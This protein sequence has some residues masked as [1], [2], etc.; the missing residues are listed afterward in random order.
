[1]IFLAETKEFK[2][3]TEIIEEPKEKVKNPSKA[4]YVPEI[5]GFTS[6]DGTGYDFEVYLPGVDKDTIRVR[7]TNEYFGILGETD[8]KQYLGTYNFC[9]PVNPEKAS[10]VYKEGLLKIH[11]PFEEVE[12][13]TIDVGVS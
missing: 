6:E 9:C 10:A 3:S 8:S 13:H 11:V 4:R 5:C 12:V 1:M 7:M 2:E